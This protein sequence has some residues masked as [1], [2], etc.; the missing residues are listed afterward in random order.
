MG[1]YT[2]SKSA[3]ASCGGS[4]PPAGTTPIL[5]ASKAFFTP[6]KKTLKSIFYYILTTNHFL[7][8]NYKHFFY[9][10]LDIFLVP[11]AKIKMACENFTER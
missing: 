11:H 1:Y 4:S 3:N 5:R 10:H 7:F 8:R 2:D 9:N 6:F